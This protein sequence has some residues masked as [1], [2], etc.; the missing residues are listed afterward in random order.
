M[1]TRVSILTLMVI[2]CGCMSQ[3]KVNTWMYG[4]P[5]ESAG[6]C[7]GMFPPDT[8]GKIVRF[9]PDTS[10]YHDSYSQLM[11]YANV[12]IDSIQGI[13]NAFKPT[14]QQ[15]CPPVFNLDSLRKAMDREIRKRLLP[16]KDSLKNVIFTVPDKAKEKHLQDIA[17][18]KDAIITKRDNT[19]SDKDNQ[20]EGLKK[21]R[22]IV[23][24][25][26]AIIGLYIFLKIRY[27]LPF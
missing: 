8:T 15:P 20:I 12:L 18:Q 13:R 21:Y 7:A 26:I 14:P 5:Q 9:E 10:K 27:K 17:D 16:C 25:I 3:R 24:V 6:I 1:A 2:L 23:W 4:H 22:T 11:D 19:I